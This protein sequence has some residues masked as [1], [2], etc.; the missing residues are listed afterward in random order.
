VSAEWELC[1]SDLRLVD[2][3]EKM[4]NGHGWEGAGRAGCQVVR[5]QGLAAWIEAFSG[6]LGA[7]ER[8][9]SSTRAEATAFLGASKPCQPTAG[10]GWTVP[11][12]LYP[13]LT[14]LLAGLAMSQLEE[15]V[16]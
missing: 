7:V 2:A 15:G 8:E 4:R 10:D 5:R 13:E 14:G 11:R 1:P 9:A 12:D 16:C 6:C 3:Y